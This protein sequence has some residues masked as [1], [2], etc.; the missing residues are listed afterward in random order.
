L[1][2]LTHYHP[3][4]RRIHANFSIAIAREYGDG[5]TGKAVSERFVRLKREPEWDLSNSVTENGGAKATPRKRATPA[6]PRSSKKKS[7][8]V[9]DDDDEDINETP[10]KKFKGSLNKTMSGRVTKTTPARA[11][12]PALGAF[13]EKSSGDEEEDIVKTENGHF[14]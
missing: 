1:S 7:V 4:L 11:S 9:S 5:V 13:A 2:S 12:R 10:S 3:T 14:E 6:K 8:E